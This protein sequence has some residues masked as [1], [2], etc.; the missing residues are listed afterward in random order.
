MS[1]RQNPNGTWSNST[2]SNQWPQRWQAEQAEQ[3][4]KQ[5]MQNLKQREDEL[6]KK[7]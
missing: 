5:M 2:D 4:H 6:K 1:V 7:K 3:D